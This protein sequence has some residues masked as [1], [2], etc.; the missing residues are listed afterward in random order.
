MSMC[1][2]FRILAPLLRY[3]CSNCFLRELD[4]YFTRDFDLGVGM[5]PS[6]YIVYFLRKIENL[7]RR[8]LKTFHLLVG[9]PGSWNCHPLGSFV[10]SFSSGEGEAKMYWR[11]S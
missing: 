11:L 5:L 10:S 3:Y 4:E 6:A 1:D 7:G 8:F 9:Q 2:D